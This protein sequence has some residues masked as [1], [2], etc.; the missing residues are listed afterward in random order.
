MEEEKAI[1]KM[2]SDLIKEAASLIESRIDMIDTLGAESSSLEKSEEL[3][4]SV[5]LV[6]KKRSLT[7]YKDT[8][9]YLS[10][11]LLTEDNRK[12]Y[13]L[14][15]Q[16]RLLLDVY[17]R[18]LHLLENCEDENSQALTCLAY[19]F[20][21]LKAIDSE[22]EYIETLKLNQPFL[23]D[24]NFSF[25]AKL[26]DFNYY[27]CVKPNNLAF[28]KQK[29]ILNKE[30][31]SKYT[32]YSLDVFGGNKTYTIYSHISE[33]MHG[34]PYYYT[35]SDQNERFW[36]STMCLISSAFLIELIDT[37]TFRKTKPR[38]FREWLKKVELEKDSVTQMW[39]KRRSEITPP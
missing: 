13:F 18:F 16:L 1:F 15:P 38:D 23:D 6:F 28:A 9:L 27:G 33:I 7:L 10:E 36:V 37:Y 22:A 19:Q 4:E 20:L 5:L 25:P 30:L 34:N 8:L 12:H 32:T 26:K 3:R 35:E 24:I 2:Q 39:I 11:E 14:L 31:I 21:T 29:D 17:T